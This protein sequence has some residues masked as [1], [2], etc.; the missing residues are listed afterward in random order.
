MAGTK[1]WS[2]NYVFLLASIGSTVGLSNI[3]KF[4]YLAGENGG[5]AFVLVYLVALIVLGIPILAAEM[6]IGKRGGKSMVGTLLVLHER[7]GIAKGWKWF[8]W[9]AMT[10]VFLILSFYCVIAGWTLDY[11]VTSLTGQ[12]DELTRETATTFYSTLLDSPGRMMIGQGVFVL[13]TTWIVAK[14]IQAGLERSIGWM[15]PTLFVILL[16]LVVYGMIFGEFTMALRFLFQPDFSK[17]TPAVFLAAFGQAFFSLGIGVGVMLTY[18]AYMP[19]GTNVLR[20]AA[21]IAFS[22]GLASMLAGLAIFPIVFKYGLSPAEGPGLIFMTLPISFGEIPGG[23]FIGALF[24]LLLFFAALTSSISLL[25]SII[26]HLEETMRFTRARITWVAGGVLWLIGLATVFSFNH[27]KSFHPLSFVTPLSQ[28]TIFEVIDYFGSN[29][30]MPL[31]GILMAVLAGWL[32]P[33]PSIKSEL[34]GSNAQFQIWRLI[35]RWL[36][37]LAVAWLMV[38]SL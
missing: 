17:I 18:G 34:L 20:S 32:L 37:P 10:T 13:A 11:T 8:G 24:F 28:K 30:L 26:S 29:L 38:Y 5:G 6:V 12:L 19:A 16:G 23:G 14:G 7:D 25:E 4:T 35:V 3:W 36:A 2:S 22:D 27:W 15:M 9:V 1:T 21:I 31:G 33:G